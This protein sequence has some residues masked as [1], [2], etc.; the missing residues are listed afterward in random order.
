[1]LVMSAA[2]A[3][4]LKAV[5]LAGSQIREEAFRQRISAKSGSMATQQLITKTAAHSLARQTRTL[6]GGLSLGPSTG[7]GVLGL[8][9]PCLDCTLNTLVSPW[10]QFKVLMAPTMAAYTS[11]KPPDTH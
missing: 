7:W 5:F 11:N 3:S 1:M 9:C 10:S 8:G 6:P 4:W 2:I